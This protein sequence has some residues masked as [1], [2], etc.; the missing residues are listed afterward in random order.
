MPSAT[1]SHGIGA[2]VRRKE[3]ARLIVGAGCFSDDVDLP[4]QARAF[5]IRSVHAHAR[6]TRIGVTRAKTLPGV[7]AVLT[8]AEYKADGGKPLPPDAS[9]TVPV[10]AQRAL[11]DVVLVNR[12]GPVV[13]TS[14]YPLAVG[15]VHYVGEAVVLVVAETLAIAKD[16][17]ELVEIDYEALPAV[18]DT[19]QAAEPDAPRLREHPRSNVF[20]DAE[21]G[22]A[23]A[24]ERAFA[25]AAHVVRLET[26][27]QRVTGVPME[28]RAAV[29]NYDAQSGRYFLHAGSGGVVRQKGELA[30]MLGVPLASVQVVALDIGGNFGTKNSIFPEFPLVLW[31]SRRIGRPVK[32]TCERSEAFLSDYQGRDLVADVELALDGRGRFLALRGS[33]LSNVGGYASSIVPL[34]K[35]IGICSGLYRVPAAHYRA[36]AVLS[37]T[38]PTIPYRSAGRPEATFV[39]ERLCDLAAIE[40]GIDRIEIRRRNLVMPDELPYRNPVGVTYDNGNYEEAMDKALSLANWKG[41]RAR[42]AE[43]KKRGKLRGIGLA[44]Y[45]ELTM[46]YPREW[47]KITVVPDGRVEVA[48][49]TLSSG[50]GHETS[51]AQCV[52]EW[53]GV[54][55][56]S[57]R[58][59]QGNTDIVPVGGGSHSGR[60][61]RMAGFVMG[62][63]AD[64]IVAKSRRIAAH[65]LKIDP[66]QVDFTE[67]RFRAKSSDGKSGQ[68]LNVFEIARAA[69]T[70]NDLDDELRGP[71]AAECDHTFKDGGYPY[72]SAVCEVEI[73]LQTGATEIVRY[74]AVDDVGRA[75]NPMILHGQT[76]G[77]IAQGVGQALWEQCVV[78][79]DSGQVMTGSFMDYAMPRAD[80]L[81]SFATELMEVPS[82]SNPLGVRAGG[83]GGTTPALAAV[84]NAVVDA[85]REFG[86]T[87]M[88]MPATSERVWR[89]IQDG[90]GLAP[91]ARV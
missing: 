80:I 53:L 9:V 62:R 59:V 75:I 14:Y 78:D 68:S 48:V 19:A 17:A 4:R 40:T 36:A 49:G 35:G 50:Q 44:N 87:H 84:I 55:F 41:F 65:V 39:I 24:T 45:I 73:D 16:A 23:A 72:G 27:V 21:I 12:D 26:W 90:K 7:F 76:H 25:A 3:D 20:L 86:V 37:N 85:L 67:G 6:I 5:V 64:A 83:E 43:A 32:W 33:H 15:K 13:P 57:I 1:K 42:R 60:S 79:R 34:R 30:G 56:D 22:D 88:D 61:M 46:G 58:L 8:G 69:Q 74:C 2:P 31:A 70:L 71:H 38:A 91:K 29:G 66:E 81:P 28:A 63:A 51:F 82:P 10:E 47:S 89:A 54:P 77:A 11:P 18:V 52:S